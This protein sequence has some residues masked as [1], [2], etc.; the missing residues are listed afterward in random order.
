MAYTVY[1]RTIAFAGICQAV[2]LVQEVAK[3][4][5]CDNDILAATLNSIVE[6][7]VII[8]TCVSFM[9]QLHDAKCILLVS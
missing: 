9:M 6:T 8:I 2:K 1:D 5:S 4:G 3:N 7:V